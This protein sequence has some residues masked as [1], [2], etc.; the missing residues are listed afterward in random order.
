MQSGLR[1]KRIIIL[2]AVIGM[3]ACVSTAYALFFQPAG[4]G[5]TF[6]V[7]AGENLAE[8]SV[9]LEQEGIVKSGLVLRTLA[10]L[11][12]LDATVKS[13]NYRLNSD[14]SPRELLFILQDGPPRVEVLIPEGASVRD[15]DDILAGKGLISP[16][17]FV[18]QVKTMSS[19]VEGYLFPDTYH[20][21]VGMT[22]AEMIKIMRD[23][24]ARKAAPE[25]P[26]DPRELQK[27]II[28]ASIL[29]KEVQTPQDQR[30]VAGIIEKRLQQ[31]MRL[32]VDASLCYAKRERMAQA[33][34]RWQGCYPLTDLDKADTSPYNTYLFEGLPPGPLGNP[35][36]SAITAAL[37]PASSDYLFYL[38]A[39]SGE[40]IFARNFEEHKRNIAKYLR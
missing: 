37:H 27:T 7:K 19:L 14:V 26:Q 39:A 22:S 38:S 34:Q 20:F 25:L 30:I 32:Q 35:G 10:K 28:L 21:T 33:G 12:H 15:I 40:T 11:E 31:G 8:L 17:E 2:G 1:G 18:Q 23:N 9:R 24:F 5:K 4:G 29:E 3:L 13:G 16:G 36:L 6:S